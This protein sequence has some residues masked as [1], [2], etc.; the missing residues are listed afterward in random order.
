MAQIVYTDVTG[1]S[2]LRGSLFQGTK[3]W[4][5][6]RVPSRSLFIEQVKAN[7]GEVVP[8]EKF[9]DVKIV[10]HF[11]K[12][13][14]PGTHSYQYIER[15][16]RNGVL[17]DLDDHRAGPSSSTARPVGAIG[18]PAKGTRAPFT[19]QDD[20]ILREWAGEQARKGQATSG[21]EI[22]KQLW[23]MNPRHPWQSWR[24]RWVKYLRPA[25]VPNNAPPTPP[26]DHAEVNT[27][28]PVSTQPV[29]TQAPQ[30][31]GTAF[32]GEDAKALLGTAK[33]ILNVHPSQRAESWQAWAEAYPQHSAQEWQN[34]W[35]AN[36]RPVYLKKLAK[37]GKEIEKP[38]APA[39]NK[40]VEEAP[41]HR[42]SP[43]K[44]Q[45]PEILS[46]SPL[47]E[48]TLPRK[49]PKKT[50]AV[51]TARTSTSGEESTE[52]PRVRVLEDSSRSPKR[53]R[54]TVESGNLTS[55]PP[56]YSISQ[57]AKR[58]RV[59]RDVARPT[60]IP[61]TPERS[62][63]SERRITPIAIKREIVDLEE[64]DSPVEE[65]EDEEIGN[66]GDG[67]MAVDQ[68]GEEE[69]EE[70]EDEDEDEAESELP[71]RAPSQSLSE[72]DY[73]QLKP[74]N[75]FKGPQRRLNFD[76]P[77]PN[78]GW[79][80]EDDSGS[81]QGPEISNTR[82]GRQ[83]TQALL[84]E[85]PLLDLSVAEPDKGWYDEDDE[86]GEDDSGSLHELE[87]VS[88]RR[89][90]RD[91]QALL[92]ET[93][94]LDLNVVE[95]EAGWDDDEDDD[96]SSLQGPENPTTRRAR[97]DTQALLRETPQLDFTVAEPD[98]GWDMQMPPLPSSPPVPISQAVANEDDRADTPEI[99]LTEKGLIAKL[100]NWID[101][102]LKN[103]IDPDVLELALKSA[104]NNP[105]LAEIVLD[106]LRK[107][108]GV[109][110]DVWGIWTE[111]DDEC[112]EAVDARR[113][114]KVMEKHGR[115]A[116]DV[117]YEFLRLFNEE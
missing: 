41:R 78:G 10:D 84:R 51:H 36:I 32:T 76:L 82:R 79:D 17:E 27:A 44:P 72:P 99:V 14:G 8:L 102:Q 18:Q 61:S 52:L 101:A 40:E 57:A 63:L 77:P 111:E 89:E 68:D 9:A 16:V 83:D 104:S 43:R 66:L 108:E 114:D 60:E 21:N 29:A 64:Y 85:T 103:G 33:D 97:Q 98:E 91:T 58:Q 90:R 48:R 39:I 96:S 24:D 5:S 112:L 53:K 13:I 6:H 73:H 47:Q 81:L 4:F 71:G 38:A 86:V 75:T 93:P 30:A 74:W 67:D 65:E 15:S 106:A 115:D 80:D 22:F 95:P 100:E 49:S 1:D 105:D 11:K 19:A 116:L 88:T 26:N 62:P 7:G 56:T 37:E 109:P 35:E 54:A 34:F 45:T 70:E 107:G 92:Q 55:S 117:R 110:D 42:K 94:L 23:Q 69:Q 50:A 46:R 2:D 59:E 25:H 31:A 20:Q 28:Q 87:I 12:G 3:F 113:I